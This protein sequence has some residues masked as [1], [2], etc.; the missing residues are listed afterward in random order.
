MPTVRKRAAAKARTKS[1]REV[2]PTDSSALPSAPAK[3][4]KAQASVSKKRASPKRKQA[5]TPRRAKS[6][7]K[8][9]RATTATPAVIALPYLPEPLVTPEPAIDLAAWSALAPPGSPSPLPRNRALAP[10][11]SGGLL[12]AIADWLGGRVRQT[13]RRIGQFNLPPGPSL[14]QRLTPQRR[15]APDAELLRLRTENEHL[16]LQLEALL[17]LQ[18]GSGSHQVHSPT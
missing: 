15:V 12:G 17:A 6:A 13:L 7:G 4:R 14:L 3:V 5:P 16:R 2:F 18:T 9:R 10:T 1:G 8:T 11:R